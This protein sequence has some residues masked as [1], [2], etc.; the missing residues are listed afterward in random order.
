M[1]RGLE[2]ISSNLKS[3]FDVVGQEYQLADYIY[4]NNISDVNSKLNKKYEVPKNFSKIYEL[5]I[6]KTLIYEIYKIK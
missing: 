5:K 3:R 1:Q 2:G 4:K 6:N